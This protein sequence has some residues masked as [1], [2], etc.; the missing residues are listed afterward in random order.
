MRGVA[1]RISG[2]RK[3]RTLRQTYIDKY[4]DH[5]LWRE[6]RH[7]RFH[8]LD[9][10]LYYRAS[11]PNYL[12]QSVLAMITMFVVLFFVNIATGG[13]IVAVIGSSAFI[14]FAMPHETTAK[15]RNVIGGHIVGVTAGAL[16]YYLSMAFITASQHTHVYIFSASVAVGLSTL[17]MVVTD[18][19]H[20]PAGGTAIWV[21]LYGLMSKGTLFI[22]I[23]CVLL[24]I[25]RLMLINKMVNLV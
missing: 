21:A 5:V 15:T 16:S 22:I 25:A 14:V 7:P 1:S 4:V 20:P 2:I 10:K 19:E 18:T 23:G 13:I 3:K 8:M 11:W 12:Y 9:P 24:A 6:N 17:M